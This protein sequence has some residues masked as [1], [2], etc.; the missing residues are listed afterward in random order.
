MARWGIWISRQPSAL[1][2]IGSMSGLG[3]PVASLPSPRSAPNATP[4][5]KAGERQSGIV[6]RVG[7]L[8]GREA[9]SCGK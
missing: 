9:Y 1:S 3:G 4:H 2:R 8:E 7:R 6:R 5:A